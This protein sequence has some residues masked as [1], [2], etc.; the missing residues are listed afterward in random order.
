MPVL[1][2]RALAEIEPLA[3]YKILRLRAEVFIVEQACA[4][5]DLDGRDAEPSA[6]QLWIE[7]EDGAVLATAR[8]LDDG[9]ARRIGRIVTHPAHRGKG[10]GRGLVEYFLSSFPGPWTLCAQAHLAGW[11]SEF[12]FEVDGDE[13][14]EIGILHVPM[15]RRAG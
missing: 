14:V 1:H 12:G 9:D 13:F 5:L 7:D 8:V 2:D 15:I 11:Y 10:M 4:Y 3:L 6:R